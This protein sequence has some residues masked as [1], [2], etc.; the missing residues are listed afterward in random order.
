[1]RSISLLAL[2][3][4]LAFLAAAS[5]TIDQDKREPGGLLIQAASPIGKDRHRCERLPNHRGR[6]RVTFLALHD[7][8]HFSR[9]LTFLLRSPNLLTRCSV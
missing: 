9:T 6:C 8:T 2:V 5:P 7:S 1:M 3:I 4:S